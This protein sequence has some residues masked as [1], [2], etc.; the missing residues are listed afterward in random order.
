MSKTDEWSPIEDLR[1]ENKQWEIDY[2][3]LALQI[4]R[5]LK[6]NVPSAL[7]LCLYILKSFHPIEFRYWTVISLLFGFLINTRRSI[8]DRTKS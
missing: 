1:P 6:K 2:L 5:F 8:K 4:Y 7:T 3:F